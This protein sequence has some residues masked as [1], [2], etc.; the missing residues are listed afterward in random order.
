MLKI[1]GRNNSINVQK[2]LWACAELGLR[3]ERIDAGGAFGVTKDP[4]YLAMNP[5]GLVPALD[6]DG[7]ILWESNTIVR[8]LAAKYGKDPLYP[9]DLQR[10]ADAERWMDW[11]L[12]TVLPAMTPIFWGLIRTPPEKRDLAAIEAGRVKLAA[13]KAILD[14]QLQG[15]AFVTGPSFTIADIPVGC[16]TYRWYALAIERP[17]YPNLKRWYDGLVA[18]PGFKTHVM[19]PLT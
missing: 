19:L 17:D 6:D 18:R 11:Q 4:A 2:V 13:A 12:T 14:R 16:M 5:N 7:F 15:K 8:Y 10:R 3:F 9:A 1:W